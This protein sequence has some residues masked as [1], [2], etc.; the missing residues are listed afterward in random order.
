[1]MNAGSTDYR[2]NFEY[3][4][5]T[6]AIEHVMSGR[7]D[8]L[9][10]PSKDEAP[11]LLY[12]QTPLAFQ[13]HCFWTLADSNWRFDNIAKLKNNSIVIY[14]DHSYANLL[15]EY[16][17]D[18][19]KKYV[20]ELFY[21]RSYLRRAYHHLEIGR[22]S[23]FLFTTNSVL[24]F[25][26][27]NKIRSL[28]MGACIKKDQLWIGLSPIKSAKISRVKALIDDNLATY[29]QSEKYQALLKKYNVLLPEIIAVK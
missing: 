12:H 27:A 28:K 9:L 29:K 2:L 18:N 11:G 21:D 19:Y 22:A 1:M 4:S 17:S 20:F 8:G 25:K 23:A 14:R 7:A 24:H 6:Q 16:F 3:S 13:T 26:K 15:A 5:W 10:S